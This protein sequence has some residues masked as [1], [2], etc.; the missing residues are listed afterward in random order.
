M[1]RMAQQAGLFGEESRTIVRTPR[2]EIVYYPELFTPGESAALFEDLLA[3]IPWSNET[4]KMYDKIVDVPRLVAW[5]RDPDVLPQSLERI[6]LR[7][8]ERLG[9]PFN[10]V[11]LNYYRDGTDSVAW[12]SDHNEELIAHPTVALVSLGATRQM[13][14][15]TKAV[16]RRQL[17]CDLEPGSLLSMVGDVQSHWEHHIPKVL[18]P[19]D[20][21]IS[22]A[23]R[24][25]A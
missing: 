12:H 15:R 20:P 25:K 24:T 4:M 3:V 19:T 1:A 23:L 11:S 2:G 16:P 18:R 13:Q 8:Q 22:V 14:F 9:T 21:R 17:R 6:R 5:Y 7:V 10:G